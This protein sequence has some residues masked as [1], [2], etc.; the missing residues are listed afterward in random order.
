MSKED[1]EVKRDASDEGYEEALKNYEER[2]DI[3]PLDERRAREVGSDFRDGAFVR[4][5]EATGVI[6]TDDTKGKKP[7]QNKKIADK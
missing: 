6:T 3:E 5:G 1:R 2:P 4:D 7:A